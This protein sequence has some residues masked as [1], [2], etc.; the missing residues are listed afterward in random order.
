MRW[1]N[2]IILLFLSLVVQVGVARLFGLG[3]Q[4]VM[5]D[6]LVMVA[7]VLA[8]RAPGDHA[9]I[10]GWILGLA[11]DLTSQ[12][13]LGC[14]AMAFGLLAWAVVHLR[15]LFYGD[16]PLTLIVFTFFAGFMVEQFVLGVCLIKKIFP[17]GNYAAFSM[18][19]MFSAMITAAIAPYGQWILMKFNRQLGLPRRRT[20]GR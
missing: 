3:P 8:F 20:Y 4:R 19:I 18:A 1:F 2:F 10:A 12:A 11:K 5:P 15:E 16:H 13:P 6:L 17:S 9:L 7:V 14:Y